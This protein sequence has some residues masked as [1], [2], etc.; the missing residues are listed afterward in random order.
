M[1]KRPASIM[2]TIPFDASAPTPREDT[3]DIDVQPRGRLAIAFPPARGESIHGYLRRLAVANGH[4]NPHTF[5][6]ALGLGRSVGPSSGDAM[7]RRL[8]AWTGYDTARLEALRWG[9]TV[10]PAGRSMVSF[11]GARVAIGFLSPRRPRSCPACLLEHGS[12]HDIWAVT[13]VIACPLHGCLLMEACAACGRPVTADPEGRPCLCGAPSDPL[14]IRSAPAAAVRV[15]RHLWKLFGG[16]TRTGLIVEPTAEFASPFDTLDAHDFLA[17]LAVFGIAATGSDEEAAVLVSKTYRSGL[18]TD[19]AVKDPLTRVQAAVAIMDGWPDAFTALLQRIERRGNHVDC[20]FTEAFSSP[21]GRMLRHPPRASSGVPLQLVHKAVDAYWNKRH[22]KRRRQRNLTVSHASA[23]TLHTTANATKLA[24][25]NGSSVASPLHRRVLQRVHEQL[26]EADRMLPK[27]EL[28]RIVVNRFEKMLAAARSTISGYSARCILEGGE[29]KET[30]TGWDRPGLLPLDPALQGL[31]YSK[32]PGYSAPAVHQLLAC[33]RTAALPAG[34]TAGLIPLL[35]AAVR[36]A[37]LRPWYRKEDLLLD[38]VAGALPVHT[39]VEAP[40]LGDMMVNLDCL[41][42]RIAT[43][44]PALKTGPWAGHAPLSVANHILRDQVGPDSSVTLN[45]ARRLV[46]AGLVR[47]IRRTST[48]KHRARP[49]VERLYRVD[50]MVA[51]AQRRAAGRLSAAD[52]S[53]LGMPCDITE[54][55]VALEQKRRSLRSIAGELTSNHFR[56]LAGGGWSHSTVAKA[57]ARSR[58]GE[59]IFAIANCTSCENAESMH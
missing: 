17:S 20:E 5:A 53:A 58:T 8:A 36:L 1:I 14:A 3:I 6:S 25:I 34:T 26:S 46:A 35:G 52:T 23:L 24:A 50:D 29:G 2:I 13:Q 59:R 12:H 10:E 47:V 31:R 22:P 39:A 21:I 30:L 19:I 33:L 42:A 7:W 18:P 54:R 28:E 56:T 4:T 9:R 43:Q 11:L 32:T 55:L 40:R 41:K 45:D 44:D 38:V 16:V 57:L 49:V 37:P 15:A 48:V 27:D 51:F